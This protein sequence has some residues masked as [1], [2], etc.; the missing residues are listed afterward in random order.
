[1]ERRGLLSQKTVNVRKGRE[2]SE[3]NSEEK[4]SI[5]KVW[6]LGTSGNVGEEETDRDQKG[7]KRND[8][9]ISRSGWVGKEK[10]GERKKEKKRDVEGGAS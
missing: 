7:W 9:E 3:K 4:D 6:M 10:R 5:R 1:V 8:E 2:D